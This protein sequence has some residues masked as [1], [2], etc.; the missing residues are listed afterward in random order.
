M[1]TKIL[2]TFLIITF[3]TSSFA[4]TVSG[5]GDLTYTKTN[6]V[7]SSVNNLKSDAYKSFYLHLQTKDETNRIRLKIKGDRYNETTSNNSNTFDLSWQLKPNNKREHNL[8]IY[9]QNYQEDP[10]IDNYSSSNNRGLKYSTTFTKEFSEEKLSYFTL[11]FNYKNYY[12]QINRKDRSIDLSGGFENSLSTDLSFSIDLSLGFI[13]STD[14]SY[15]NYNL[16][17]SLSFNYSFTDTL[18]AYISSSLIYTAY[19]NQTFE[20]TVR[21]RTV[22]NKE[23]QTLFSSEIGLVS[24]H[25]DNIP[26][27]IKQQSNKNS[28]NNPESAYK[29][30]LFSINVSFR[31]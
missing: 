24:N 4:W 21:N 3:S 9:Q 15:S 16:G 8:G 5:R 1:T 28:S 18:E 13:S 7:N 31:F 19:S 26:I 29:S 10:T 12:Q 17:P 14:S 22:I 2:F 11:G 23:Q 25:F 6:N 20:T 27:T 30:R